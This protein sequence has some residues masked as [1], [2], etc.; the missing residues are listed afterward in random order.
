MALKPFLTKSAVLSFVIVLFWAQSAVAQYGGRRSAEFNSWEIGFSGGV[1][2]FS[3]SIN[4]NSDA[5]YK[6]FN[7]WNAD[8]NAAVTLSVIKNFSPKFSA[9]FEWLSTKLSGSWNSNNGYPIPP[10]TLTLGLPYPNPFKTGI[11]QFALMFVPNLNKIFAPNLANDRWYL[12]LKGG[13]GGTLIKEYSALFP[14]DKKAGFKFALAYGG[15]LSYTIN[16]KMK[17]KLGVMWYRVESDRLDGVHTAKPGV[18]VITKDEDL[19]YNVKEKY[20][21]PYI[22]L[23]YG[24]GTIQSKAHF[25]QHNNNRFL[26]FKSA[27]HK[28]KKRR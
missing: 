19:V 20:F 18:V 23:T 24:L 7:Y 5:T 26:W 14:L 1:S 10:P 27:A 16:E 28:Y 6:K 17:L 11:N 13:F 15:G 22:G 12:F 9:E 21:Y 2:Q 25:I 4:P 3:N 8:Y